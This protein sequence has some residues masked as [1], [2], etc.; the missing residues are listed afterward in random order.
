MLGIEVGTPEDA[1]FLVSCAPCSALWDRRPALWAEFVQILWVSQVVS[2]LGLLSCPTAALQ[3]L[4]HLG[5][6]LPVTVPS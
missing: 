3:T 5:I 6:P 4:I 2:I 1:R